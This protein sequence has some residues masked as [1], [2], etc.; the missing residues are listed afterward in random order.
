V[1]AALAAAHVDTHDRL[2]PAES[3]SEES[4]EQALHDHNGS[5]SG[6]RL[7]ESLDLG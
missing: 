7:D 4:A 6:G 5:S 1:P 3:M 2:G